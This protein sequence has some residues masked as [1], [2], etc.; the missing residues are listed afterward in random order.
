M[1]LE[2]PAATTRVYI[3]AKYQDDF[4]QY[5]AELDRPF[6]GSYRTAQVG[7]VATKPDSQ[8][9]IELARINLEAGATEVRLPADP[10][11][12]QAKRAGSPE[13]SSGPRRWQWWRP[14]CRP[15]FVSALP[16]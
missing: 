10:G 11:A 4:A 2:S 13:A 14:S 6:A 3:A 15:P 1:T 12:P 7:V 8:T 16:S 5:L 9:W